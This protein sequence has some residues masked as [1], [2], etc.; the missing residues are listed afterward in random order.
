M[1]MGTASEVEEGYKRVHFF[2]YFLTEEDWN[3]RHDYHV[4][5]NLLHMMYMHGSGIQDGNN[6]LRVKAQVVPGLKVDVTPGVAV[7]KQGH[8]LMVPAVDAATFELDK[9]SLPATLYVKIVYQ[10]MASDR[11]K[12][13]DGRIENKYFRETYRFIVSDKPA[14]EKQIEL[15]RVFV[16]QDCTAIKDAVDPR[17]PG[18]NEIDMTRRTAFSSQKNIDKE[19]QLLMHKLLKDRKA[20]FDRIGGNSRLPEVA[21]LSQNFSIMNE[22]LQANVLKESSITGMLEFFEVLDKHVLHSV[23]ARMDPAAL[24]RPEWKRHLDN[25]NAF[26]KIIDQPG[27][28]MAQKLSM[29]TVQLEKISISYAHV[30]RMIGNDRR[31]YIPGQ[32]KPLPKVYPVTH[33]W[34][35]V[36]TWSAE[37]PQVMEIDDMEWLLMGELNITDEASEKKYKFRIC[38]ARD[39]W[40]NRQRL[41]FPDGTLIEDTGV[42]QEGGYCEFDI[43]N[44]IPDTH[45]AVIRMMD[46]ARGDYELLISVNGQNAGISRCDGYDRQA[47]W[48]NWPF[49]IPSYFVNNTTLRV[50]QSCVTADRD[51]NMFRYWFYQPVNW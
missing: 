45:L 28:S 46:Y 3:A 38:D 40:K 31:V 9:F 41:S 24:E 13:A 12:L 23:I 14:S 5:K 21:L 37:M 26:K 18:P 16:T 36:K 39:I 10:E 49:V 11:V 6:N 22:L 51:I 33:N 8:V 27:K 15:A 17:N 50:R 2:K 35:F 47:R 43:P 44:V 19:T 32:A 30:A 7:D 1:S 42:A 48:R 25:C 29:A 4:Q 34:E 20:A